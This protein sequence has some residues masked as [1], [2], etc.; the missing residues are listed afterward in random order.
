MKY[1]QMIKRT[2]AYFT[3]FAEISLQRGIGHRNISTGIAQSTCKAIFRNCLYILFMVSLGK[4]HA[5]DIDTSKSHTARV[6]YYHDRFEGR[7]TSN[8]EHFSQK[9][10]TAAHHNYKFGTLLLITNPQNNNWVIVKVNDRCP[11][12]GI[13]DLSKVAAKQLGILH[14]GTIR[15]KVQPLPIS[16]YEI[17]EKQDIIFNSLNNKGN[18]SVSEIIE[19]LNKGASQTTDSTANKKTSPKE[20]PI[21]EAP[22]KEKY[23]PMVF[24]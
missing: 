16:Y 15:V 12:R 4:L 21:K 14:K 5:Q 8:G 7:K 6:T 24:E 20:T 1:Y 2:F 3:S 23:T 17:W 19:H 10:Y 11:K 13:V 22:Q 18:K 9:N